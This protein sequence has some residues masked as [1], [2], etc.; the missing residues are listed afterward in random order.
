VENVHDQWATI[1][2]AWGDDPAG[3]FASGSLRSRAKV[4]P[5]GRLF[6]RHLGEFTF[7]LSE[8]WTTIVA[9]Q[10][11]GGREAVVLMQRVPSDATLGTLTARTED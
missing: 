2:L 7:Q 1:L 4:L 3:R 5:D 10:G 6:W 11:Q 8:D 9:K